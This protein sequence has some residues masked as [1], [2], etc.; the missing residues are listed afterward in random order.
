MISGTYQGCESNQYLLLGQ[1]ISRAVG[2]LYVTF[3]T[4]LAADLVDSVESTDDELLQEQ[5]G[6][7]TKVELHVQL[8]V[9]SLEWSG[10]STTSDLVHHGCLNLEEVALV[11][12]LADVLDYL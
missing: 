11:K 4:E 5:F 3:V 1:Q 9:V 8:V 10:C 6:S 2:H 12:V 7:D